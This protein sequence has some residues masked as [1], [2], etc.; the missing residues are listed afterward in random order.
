MTV[1]SYRDRSLEIARADELVRS[2]FGGAIEIRRWIW[3]EK[4]TRVPHWRY[5]LIVGDEVEMIGATSERGA[6]RD[7]RDNRRFIA[8]RDGSRG[9]SP[10]GGSSAQG[11]Q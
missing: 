11:Q 7:A 1:Q 10:L 6:V 4:R 9:R 3:H 8:A 5:S 2:F